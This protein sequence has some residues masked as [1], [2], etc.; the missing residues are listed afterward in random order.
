MT[1]HIRKVL[2]AKSVVDT[3]NKR[4]Y[5]GKRQ[6]RSRTPCS[7]QKSSDPSVNGDLIDKLACNPDYSPL[8]REIMCMFLFVPS[9]N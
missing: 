6:S 7:R 5:S 3:R 1:N 4:Y 8:V 2:S 9:R